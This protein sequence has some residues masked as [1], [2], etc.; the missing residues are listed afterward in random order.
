M[1]QSSTAHVSLWHCC[2]PRCYKIIPL[3]PVYDIQWVSIPEFQTLLQSSPKQ[4]RRPKSHTIRCITPAANSHY[5]FLSVSASSLVSWI[6]DPYRREDIF[7][8]WLQVTLTCCHRRVTNACS[9]CF[10][11]RTVKNPALREWAHPWWAVFPP[12]HD[13]DNPLQ[14]PSAMSL[15]LDNPSQIC[16]EI[17]QVNNINPQTIKSNI[18]GSFSWP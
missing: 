4:S 17:C 8:S 2:L 18:E 1:R 10:S 11:I 5:Q 6:K 9:A 3:N 15:S 16:W 14:T 12:Q 7:I 13:K